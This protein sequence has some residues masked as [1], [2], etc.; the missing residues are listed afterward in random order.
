MAHLVAIKLQPKDFSLSGQDFFGFLHDS[1]L[2]DPPD[3]TSSIG[4]N[5][6]FEV[7]IIDENGS[8]VTKLF[9][10]TNY[11]VP[12]PLPDASLWQEGYPGSGLIEDQTQYDALGAT[13]ILCID[14]EPE[15][16]AGDFG[17]PNILIPETG[18]MNVTIKRDAS[19]PTELVIFSGSLVYKVLPN[20]AV[21]TTPPPS[22]DPLYSTPTCAL[23]NS[24]NSNPTADALLSG[25]G[26]PFAA[27]EGLIA[28]IFGGT[29]PPGLDAAACEAI[30]LQIVLTEIVGQGVP[31]P[32][33]PDGIPPVS[34]AFPSFPPDIGE[35][36][37]AINSVAQLAAA[38][39]AIDKIVESMI[40]QVC[41][42]VLSIAAVAQLKAAKHICVELPLR[43]DLIGT[44]G[45][46]LQNRNKKLIVC[47]DSSTSPIGAVLNEI[48]AEHI[49]G[50]TADSPEEFS[51]DDRIEQIT[52][53]SRDQIEKQLQKAIDDGK[54][55]DFAT[56]QDRERIIRQLDALVGNLGDLPKCEIP[57]VSPSYAL[58]NA[59]ANYNGDVD[60]NVFWGALTNPQITG[61][62][63]LIICFLAKGHTDLVDV[64]KEY[65]TY[66]NATFSIPPAGITDLVALDY[67]EWIRFFFPCIPNVFCDEGLEFSINNVLKQVA[68]VTIRLDFDLNGATL[69]NVLEELTGL[70]PAL[71]NNDVYFDGILTVAP[72]DNGLK[73]KIENYL[74]I[75][76]TT[77]A[78]NNLRGLSSADWEIIIATPYT[79]T[80]PPTLNTNF[81]QEVEKL[82]KEVG[83]CWEIP[84]TTRPE[85][86][87]AV[88]LPAMFDCLIDTCVEDTVKNNSLVFG[89]STFAADVDTIVNLDEC[90]K[91][92]LLTIHGIFVLTTLPTPVEAALQFSLMEALYARGFTNATSITTLT[93]PDFKTALTGTVAYYYS[94]EIW[95]LANTEVPHISPA[96]GSANGFVPINPDGDLR[97]SLPPLHQSQ[98][99][100]VSYLHELLK[101]EENSNCDTPFPTPSNALAGFL[102]KRRGDIA[103]ILTATKNNTEVPIPLIDIVNESLEHM[104]AN[105]V[106]E[107]TIH[108]TS[109]KGVKGLSFEDHPVDKL[110]CAIPEH[111]APTNTPTIPAANN[112]YTKLKNAFNGPNLP[113]DQAQ[114][115]SDNLL[116]ELGVSL[117]DLK[118]KH[119]TD[120]TEFCLAPNAGSVP[121]E[122]G[123]FK[124]HLWRFPVR[125]EVAREYLGITKEE[126]DFLYKGNLTPVKVR[127]LYGYPPG[128]VSWD[129]DVRKLSEFLERTCLSYDD[130]LKLWKSDFVLFTN[131]GPG[132]PNFPDKKPHD[133][134]A[135]IIN[136][137]SG[138]VD[139]NLKKTIVF[140]RI[141]QQL[142]KVENANYS[143]EEL[144]DIAEVLQLFNGNKVN[145]EFIRQLAAF[146]LF[147]D[148][149]CLKLKDENEKTLSGTGANRQHIL[150]LW[151]ATSHP[152]WNWAVDHL[153]A[154]IKAK[155]EEKFEC[156]ARPEVIKL[157]RKEAVLNKLSE[158]ANFDPNN[159]LFTW[160]TLPTH[161]IRFAEVLCKIYA[162]NFDVEE[163][164]FL[165]TAEANK[166]GEDP[167]M[168]PSINEAEKCPFN[169]PDCSDFTLKKLRDQLLAI[170]FDTVEL[171]EVNKCSL[172]DV[173]KIL[174]EEFCYLF[175]P[176]SDDPLES[177]CN[178]FFTV[179][180]EDCEDS[181]LI[182]NTWYCVPLLKSDTSDDMWDEPVSSP[183]F[184]DEDNDQLCFTL[185]LLNKD[186]INKLSTDK[187]NEKETKA[188]RDLFFLP[189]KELAQLG[190]LFSNQLEA[191]EYLIQEKS[192]LKRLEYFLKSFTVFYERSKVIATFIAEHIASVDT[193]ASFDG[194]KEVVWEILK[195][196][197][198][199]ENFS[200]HAS[201]KWEDDTGVVP[202]VA[203]NPLPHGG[204]FAAINGLVG[205]GLL[206]EFYLLEDGRLKYD[207]DNN[208]TNTVLWRE[209]RGP[210]SSFGKEKNLK[211]SPVISVVPSLEWNDSTRQ[212]VTICNGFALDNANG[213]VLGGA[214]PYG[215]RWKGVLL[216]DKK[217]AYSFNAGTPTPKGEAPAY[218]A[219]SIHQWTVT[220]KRGEKVIE[221][222][223]KGF[224]ENHLPCDCSRSVELLPCAYEIIIDYV[225][226]VPSFENKEEVCP[227]QAGFELKYKGPDTEDQLLTVPFDKL[228]RDC[229]DRLLGDG[230]PLAS[231][232]GSIPLADLGGEAIGYLNNFYTS[233]IRDIRRTYQRAFKAGLFSHRFKLTAN[234]TTRN[235]SELSFLLDHAEDFAG[236]S[237][238]IDGSG[239]FISHK[240]RFNFSFLPVNDIYKKPSITIDDRNTSSIKRQQ[241]LFD[242][243]EKIFDY[244]RLEALV[245]KETGQPLWELFFYE[246]DENDPTDPPEANRLERYLGTD[247]GYTNIG[248]L[249]IFAPNP[250]LEHA[251]LKN[252]E[253]A[254]RIFQ[255]ASSL[256][257][258]TANI[259]SKNGIAG[260]NPSDWANGA[261]L[262]AL[263]EY[264]CKTLLEDCEPP[265]YEAVEQINNRLRV[266][267]RNALLAYLTSENRVKLPWQYLAGAG[268]EQ[269]ATKAKHLS[270]LL[271]MDVETSPCLK[272]SRVEEAVTAVQNYIRR[273]RIGLEYP[274]TSPTAPFKSSLDFMH[275]WDK[276]FATY[277]IWKKCKMREVFNE[278]WIEYDHLKTARKSEAFKV[279]EDKLR[280]QTLAVPILDIFPNP[281]PSNNVGGLLL[282]QA[283]QAIT[284]KL[285]ATPIS[286]PGVQNDT[287]YGFDQ[288]GTPEVHGR[289]SWLTSLTE[290]D[291]S[292][293]PPK[294]PYWI[295]TA[296]RLGKKFVRVAAA[297]QPLNR[298]YCPPV[299]GDCCETCLEPHEA[300]VD[301]Y[302][303]WLVGSEFFE[304]IPQSADWNWHSNVDL[305]TLLS[306]TA[307]KK[308]LLAWT[309]IHNGA[310]EQLRF[311]DEGVHVVNSDI[312]ELEFLGRTA[313]TLKF[314]VI[315]GIVPVGY[316]S[317]PIDTA[318]LA[319]PL[320]PEPG[321]RYFIVS[322]AAVAL[323]QLADPLA[324]FTSIGNLS[325]FP[326]FAYFAPGAPVQPTSLFSATLAVADNL[327]SHC[328]FEI[329]LKVYE[330]YYNPLTHDNTWTN[331][332]L[333]N[334]DRSILLHY[335]ETLLQWGDA[336]M[337][338]HSPEAFQQARM[339]YDITCKI[340]GVCPISIIEEGAG[341]ATTIGAY[342]IPT[343]SPINPRLLS[344]FEE[345]EDRLNLVRRCY[346]GKKLLNGTPNKDMPYFGDDPF[347]CGWKTNMD[348]CVDELEA[349]LPHS[350]YR[351]QFLLQK[352][353]EFAGEV[354]SLGGALLSAYEK[355]DGEYLASLRAYHEKQL[356]ELA[357][358]IRQDQ[359][360]A[361]DWDVQGLYK[362]KEMA[363]IRLAYNQ[364]LHAG[365]L[366][367]GESDY[368][369][370]THLSLTEL[371]LSKV[372]E[373][374]AQILRGLP[375]ILAGLPQMHLPITGSKLAG[376]VSTISQVFSTMSQYHGTYAGLRNTEGGW[377]RREREWLHQ[378][379]LITVEIQQIERQIL[380]S[381]R[382]RDVALK[383][384]NNQVQQIENSKEVFDFMK[385]K[386]SNHELYLWM[387]KETAALH[388][389]M[390]ELA[391]LLGRQAER[392][393]NYERGFTTKKFIDGNMLWD[394]LHEG[395]LAGERLQHSLRRMEKAYYDENVR[396]YELT[397]HISLRQ[398]F[399]LEFL[400]LKET[401]C[402]TIQI[403]EWMFDMD[404]PGHYMRR[405][406][407]MSLSIPCV[408]GPYTGVHSR[409]TL[410]SGR[411]RIKP[412]LHKNVDDSCLDGSINNGYPALPD[413]PR[414]VHQ[415]ISSEAIATS[416]GQN[417]SGMFE[418]NF[419]DDR[420]LPFEY[421]GAISCWRLELPRENNFFDMDS[422]GDVIMHLNYTAREGGESLR[423]AAQEVT[424]EF[425]PG[426]GKHLLDVIHEL[427]DAW[428]QFKNC[429]PEKE[430]RKLAFKLSQ[431]MFPYLPCDKGVAID[432]L[433]LVLEVTDDFQ[434]E[435]FNLS[436]VPDE[437][438]CHV[439]E[440][441]KSKDLT[442]SCIA[443]SDW[444]KDCDC[445][446]LFQGKI[447][448]ENIEIILHGKKKSIGHL[449]LPKEVKT[450]KNFYCLFSYSTVK[451]LI[452]L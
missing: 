89:S 154:Q 376:F 12:A 315:G 429:D 435:Q 174:K 76:P 200:T 309:K 60:I 266:N 408:V 407:N 97:N 84:C 189:R 23:I 130:F 410:I 434:A 176:A 145:A 56:D 370:Y 196:L 123:D 203:W 323:P 308:V 158:L 251:N 91:N 17:G 9:N 335:L 34:I 184:Y 166:G 380:A 243:W 393:Y 220:I 55:A 167:F 272:M 188:V 138:T 71:S 439:S 51:L 208:I 314:K 447:P 445:T 48:T 291:L 33:F 377:D 124:K 283:E 329:A 20:T 24:P 360:R 221:L 438:N 101:L 226:P 317:G 153:L 191:I 27:L 288:L 244:K 165:F 373:L 431:H 319:S 202:K 25:S 199:D 418:L 322:D 169:F 242:W 70:D 77:L 256:D 11:H 279:L 238:Y 90:C 296:I 259:D 45:F 18:I 113:Y 69:D 320:H 248:A 156:P 6:N 65:V 430:E 340:L 293:K 328:R 190:F 413:D 128:I 240:A 388:S 425:L 160:H 229:K 30:A 241:A 149:F 344:L 161:T 423:Y 122:P 444:K 217:G 3:G 363:Q 419:T 236:T 172:K 132:T 92:A 81:I 137:T 143:F 303:F 424:N 175:D 218:D 312:A 228:F 436:F 250:S 397:K 331:A 66:N 61:H 103:G 274:A 79:A 234:K 182:S 140:I 311:S 426:N 428:H 179:T 215:V 343:S 441:S 269:Y 114:D 117:F 255:S 353:Q 298:I 2:P 442:I 422:L 146:Q 284:Q 148:E 352:A 73:D 287:R 290:R 411:T 368:I 365:G 82:L 318:N 193:A 292:A 32:G 22:N 278:N 49:Q 277:H 54:I 118:R 133:L 80:I 390:Y 260:V 342:S 338:Q 254:I 139:V 326:S 96:L 349:C 313:D 414:W 262:D 392:A 58:I 210:M 219:N 112:P 385:D 265:R 98:T 94:D 224:G 451:Q 170:N 194:G 232:T 351:F 406:K 102:A 213:D 222:L 400:M 263:A 207:G 43:P 374:G 295:E 387:Q 37:D 427:P 270:E 398:H 327:R 276:H 87:S 285:L 409:L 1:D 253:W 151:V 29:I 394:N 404:Y 399:P 10:T 36:M 159:P 345:I 307:E 367:G 333:T 452:E 300:M 72:L 282:Q 105:K 237:Y 100:P 356:L 42:V 304:A 440:N 286:P 341:G 324:N 50:L 289:P 206:G 85:P 231:G 40:K 178:R 197:Y 39:A 235:Q 198:A 157:I 412:T 362:T 136:F 389:Q 321:F 116:G 421:A 350:P 361:S 230:L 446:R 227:V 93:K 104:V 258:L 358:S 382:R 299:D 57:A 86:D 246:G 95:D 372:I 8:S 38:P 121:N 180:K 5:L 247:L 381:E 201:I 264:V 21:P 204:A 147:R 62:L 168:L 336:L 271:L 294:V 120:I 449:V 417:D 15:F 396:E 59:W 141:W 386:F 126:Y 325:A 348:V 216:I 432:C 78:T 223:S 186:V 181:T 401:G 187:L 379:E 185:P 330:Q 402:C 249:I 245:T 125:F 214:M 171:S 163:I 357:L 281:A 19:L 47:T 301:E 332:A 99:G 68:K 310:F 369:S 209:V 107:G 268:N 212:L 162:S 134:S 4:I 64:I 129:T 152:K 280:R 450:I 305:P 405:I 14:V 375:D 383:E 173:K 437:K 127:N 13:A 416:N 273:V 150:A 415:F 155:C 142:K 183:F 252:E 75:P 403:P 337:K 35:L 26:L 109:E 16:L 448:L 119:N 110:L 443:A 7:T 346:N 257:S 384:L 106:T 131:S 420:Y 115:I 225:V 211:N 195:N 233:T 334:N 53:M 297:G 205:T 192:A 63:D 67:S 339:V 378:I 44:P 144:R 108:N 74:G 433:E 261:D 52:L 355:G 88:P 164:C 28:D 267:A 359:W 391:L 275:L 135:Y 177:I 364:E 41:D 371:I 111:S 347:K 306:W 302:Y 395:M 354:T 46:D 239:D 366:N 83:R 316:P 31:L